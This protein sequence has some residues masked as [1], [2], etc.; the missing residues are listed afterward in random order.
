MLLGRL[1]LALGRRSARQLASPSLHIGLRYILYEPTSKHFFNPRIRT[2]CMICSGG[3]P[4]QSRGTALCIVY[5]AIMIVEKKFPK[6]FTL[7]SRTD[8]SVA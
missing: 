3:K 2:C 5:E 8:Q 6:S 4:G 7:D 1:G